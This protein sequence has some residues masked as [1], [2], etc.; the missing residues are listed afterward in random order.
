MSCRTSSER[1]LTAPRFSPCW[2]WIKSTFDLSSFISADTE[3]A[4]I[5]YSL[6]C[7]KARIMAMF[8]AMA[9]S[10]LSRPDSI[11]TPCSVKAK[12]SAD[13]GLFDVITICDELAAHSSEVNW[14][15]KSA[16]NL[17]KFLLT[18]W[19]SAWVGLYTI[20]ATV[21]AR[22]R[23]ALPSGR[24]PSAAGSPESPPSRMLWTRGICPRRGIP[25]F[26]AIAAPPSFPNI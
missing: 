7:T 19:F 9:T 10:L 18:D 1:S 23:K 6:T 2:S 25:Y 11:A 20:P 17:F 14:N 8:A 24:S 26:C 12:G 21:R 4:T 13:F 5:R 3:D 22:S 16:G 15:I